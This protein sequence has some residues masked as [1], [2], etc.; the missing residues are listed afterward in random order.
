VGNGPLQVGWHGATGLGDRWRSL[1]RRIGS[2]GAS[3]W[4]GHERKEPVG[5]PKIQARAGKWPDSVNLLA[6]RM[7][8]LYLDPAHVEADNRPLFDEMQKRCLLCNSRDRCKHDL[9]TDTHDGKWRRYC[10]NGAALRRLS[11]NRAR[12]KD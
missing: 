1:W 4:T 2:R 7:V 11:Q 6:W 9:T 3:N 5:E 12:E 10:A 8:A